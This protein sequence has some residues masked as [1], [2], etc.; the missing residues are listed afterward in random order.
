[1][2]HLLEVYLPNDHY[3]TLYPHAIL[4]KFKYAQTLTL[5][6]SFLCQCV[7]VFSLVQYKPAQ[8]GSEYYPEWADGI[9][10]CMTMA[11]VLPIP[12]IAIY[13]YYV[14][15]GQGFWAVS[16]YTVHLYKY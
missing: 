15:E 6:R 12:A 9:G 13:K 1:M 10:W 16:D 4:S 14:A 11:S 2:A 5:I 8:Y 7:L 3:G